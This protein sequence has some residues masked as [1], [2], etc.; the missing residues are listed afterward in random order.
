MS[1]GPRRLPDQLP[2]IKLR[3]AM[4]K[5]RYLQSLADDAVP[6]EIAILDRILG[7]AYTQLV[8]S[9]AR[10]QIADYVAESPRSIDELA[11]STG[12][13][14]DALDRTLRALIGI[15]VFQREE[16]GRIGQNRVSYALRSDHPSNSRQYALLWGE[17]AVGAAWCDLGESVHSGAGAFER[18]HGADVWR[19][20]DVHEDER[21]L[22]AEAMAGR[23]AF[24]APSIARGYPFDVGPR[25]CDVGGGRG[26]VLSEILLRKTYLRGV[27]YER[28][29][30]L[31]SARRLFEQR[32]VL[33]RVELVAGDYLERIP[34][35]CES[36]L[37]NG[38]LSAWNDTRAVDILGNCRTAMKRGHRVIVVDAFLDKENPYDFVDDV[39]CLVMTGGRQRS[40]AELAELLA[41]AGFEK[42]RTID[43]VTTGV[44]EGIAR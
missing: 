23:S 14:C 30:M 6:P 39:R 28:P 29:S 15:G 24:E 42:N 11:A 33:D 10:L 27:L 8:A 4:E 22:F 38:V 41:R 5:R 18:V 16:D 19:W 20:L 7:V 32:G 40:Q 44:M 2:P 21:D 17:R 26:I 1:F 13:N 31:A 37:L 9:A 34:E 36:Y 3:A 25:V 12:A 35:G 43:L